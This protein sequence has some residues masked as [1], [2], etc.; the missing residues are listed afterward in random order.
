M[1]RGSHTISGFDQGNAVLRKIKAFTL[2]ELLVVVA[3]IGILATVVVVNLSGAQKK[4]RDSKRISDVTEIEKAL[5]LKIEADG[6]SLP[7]PRP[8]DSD[9]DYGW[10]YDP[11]GNFLLTAYAQANLTEYLPNPPRDPFNNNPSGFLYYL[12]IGKGTNEPSSDPNVQCSTN[13]T[14]YE[15]LFKTEILSDLR[16]S[17]FNTANETNRWCL[18]RESN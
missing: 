15:I 5:L 6:S 4:A 10:I 1:R 8:I 16:Y 2:I 9:H 12:R 7:K 3:I 14:F 17:R 11:P 18:Y 13:A